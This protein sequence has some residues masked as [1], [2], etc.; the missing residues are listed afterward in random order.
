MGWLPGRGVDKRNGL[1]L[2]PAGEQLGLHCSCTAATAT[3]ASWRAHAAVRCPARP[4]AVPSAQCAAAVPSAAPSA[5][6]RP[7]VHKV[8][9]LQESEAG[10]LQPEFNDCAMHLGGDVDPSSIFLLHSVPGLPGSQEV[11][12]GL[13]VSAAR[14][15]QARQ[16]AC[17][18]V[19]RDVPAERGGQLVCIA[20]AR[21]L[22]PYQPILLGPRRR[23]CCPVASADP[24]YLSP[25]LF[26]G[27][28][29]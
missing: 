9:D 29:V 2:G 12:P 19:W 21:P 6:C 10:F 20:A 7:T 18:H 13:Y 15:S 22:L 26:A 5:G 28:R 17:R 14:D 4:P 25:F 8:G 11:I 27:W 1:A 24:A 3:A 16:L 23:R